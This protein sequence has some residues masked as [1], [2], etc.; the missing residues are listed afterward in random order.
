VRAGGGK[1]K[2]SKFEREVCRRLSL[3]VTDGAKGDVFWRSAMSGGRATVGRGEVRQAGDIAAVAPEG[4]KFC[5]QWFIECKHVRTLNLD[6]FLIKHTGVLAKFWTKAR[7]EANRYR[8]H[9][10]IIA[11][12]NGWPILVVSR[13]GYVAQWAQPLIRTGTCDVTLFDDLLES[14]FADRRSA[15]Q[16]QSA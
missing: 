15:S 16:R 6:S 13:P 9:P 8:R 10:L 1:Q 3:W 11:R 7:R 4:Y 14:K 2:G 12:Q 5:D